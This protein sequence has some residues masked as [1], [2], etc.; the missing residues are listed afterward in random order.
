MQET[1]KAAYC[2]G[3][4]A[5]MRLGIA[6]GAVNQKRVNVDKLHRM[7]VSISQNQVIGKLAEVVQ[8]SMDRRLRI[9]PM[10]GEIG[11]ILRKQR[12]R[13]RL[14]LHRTWRTPVGRREP[15]KMI[16][17]I[18]RL[19]SASGKV[20]RTWIE[21]PSLRIPVYEATN[22]FEGQFLPL[23]QTMQSAKSAK[24]LDP[25][26]IDG[27]CSGAQPSLHAPDAANIVVGGS[28]RAA[29]SL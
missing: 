18:Q 21:S 22:L 3:N 15:H 8:L 24:L 17:T 12:R 5:H 11:G 16:D 28:G 23:D 1:A 27:H 25:I 29:A 19:Q 10:L 6:C 2:A 4:I 14:H 13:W 7:P 20:E 9:T 26:Q